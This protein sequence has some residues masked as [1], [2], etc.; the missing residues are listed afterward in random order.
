MSVAFWC[1]RCTVVETPPEQDDL[2]DDIAYVK[3]TCL[4][5][6]DEREAW[7]DA[8]GNQIHH[9]MTRRLADGT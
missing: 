9:D 8:D 5:G 3:W 2:P 4:C 7:F 6:D 1:I